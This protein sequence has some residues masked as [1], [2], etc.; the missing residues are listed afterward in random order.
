MHYKS[1]LY[2]I[3]LF[4]IQIRDLGIIL[5]FKIQRWEQANTVN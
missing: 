3:L 1:S 5:H 4:N 2:Y